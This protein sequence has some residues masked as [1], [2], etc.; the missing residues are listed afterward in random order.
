MAGKKNDPDYIWK[1]S[2]FFRILIPFIAGLTCETAIPKSIFSIIPVFFLS[3]LLVI[4]YNSITSRRIYQLAWIC[5]IAIQIIFFS[6]AGIL[7]HLYQDFPVGENDSHSRNR[8]SSLLLQLLSDPTSKK[9]SFKCIARISWLIK[10]H[11]CIHENE[12]L[13]VYFNKKLDPGQLSEGSLIIIRKSLQ[14]IENSK[15]SD[16]D[17]KKYCRLRHIYAQVFLNENDFYVIA[18]EKENSIL[19]EL[20]TLRKKIRI[21]IKKYIPGISENSL[22]EALMVGFTDDLDP[23]LLKSYADAGVMHIIAISGLHLAL[24]CHILQLALKKT[25]QNKTAK[26]ARFFSI[27]LIL[28][29][30]SLLSGASPSVIRSA[31]MFSILLLGRNLLRESVLYNTLAA[32]A[33]LLLCFDPNWLWD[34]GFQLSYAAVLSLRL[35]SGPVKELIPLQNKILSAIWEAASVSIAA[36]ILTIPVSIYYFHRFPSYFLISNLLAVPLSSGILIGGIGLSISFWIPNAGNA[37]G[38]ILGYGI[39]MLNGFIRRV[40]RL[41]GAVISPI[42]LSLPQLILAYGIIFCFYRF[43]KWK[44]KGWLLAGLSTICLFQ[45]CNYLF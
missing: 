27:M 43:L 19:S 24:I 25:G 11:T 41:P 12:K 45:L 13:L 7:V 32:S 38:W 14:P 33:F 35:F 15:F 40:S 8:P 20:A 42:S 10:D 34:T 37:I 23:G 39:E 4:I 9:N 30:Y 36:Q 5:G 29:G 26:W 18:Q 21:I 2:P 28:W 17:Y 3:I 1:L 44:E 6:L 22:M 31:A 16:F